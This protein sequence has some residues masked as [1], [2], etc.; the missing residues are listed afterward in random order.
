MFLPR[1]SLFIK[2]EVAILYARNNISAAHLCCL[3]A[4]DSQ[5]HPKTSYNLIAL[6]TQVTLS[7]DVE[8]KG[9]TIKLL[10]CELKGSPFVEDLNNKFQAQVRPHFRL[11]I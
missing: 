3:Q 7:V 2:T 11:L 4:L 1:F 10:S 9:C 5:H 6:R 8:P